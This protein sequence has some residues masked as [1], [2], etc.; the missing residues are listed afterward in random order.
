MLR[1]FTSNLRRGT[2]VR[3]R[4][5]G[6]GGEGTILDERFG[7]TTGGKQRCDFKT[8]KSAKIDSSVCYRFFSALNC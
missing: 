2:L 1:L 3:L 6:L 5:D 8:G 4:S 7:R